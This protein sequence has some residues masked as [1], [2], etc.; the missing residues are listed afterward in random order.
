MAQALAF[1]A[2]SLIAAAVMAEAISR[3]IR[4]AAKGAAAIGNLDFDK[5]TP[6]PAGFFRETHN[7]AISFNAML[8]GLKALGA[9]CRTPWSPG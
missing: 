5:V 6:L 2:V 9:M 8:E 4:R 1:L 3:P 7:L